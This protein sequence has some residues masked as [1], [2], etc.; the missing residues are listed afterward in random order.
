MP[1]LLEMICGFWPKKISGW[2]CPMGSVRTNLFEIYLGK[3]S[4]IHLVIVP[5]IGLILLP[6]ICRH[7][8]LV[9]LIFPT[10]LAFQHFPNPKEVE[11]CWT[12]SLPFRTD[13]QP[14]AWNFYSTVAA[15]FPT[16][17][18][19]AAL[20]GTCNC[21]RT[22]QYSGC[23]VLGRKYRITDQSR[24]SKVANNSLVEPHPPWEL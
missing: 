9:F 13:Y 15:Q 11:N 7:R 17:F 4:S 19:S 10:W 20:H 24:G 12:R 23:T 2:I 16:G 8:T 5:L 18:L 3:L 6:I 21:S 22:I 14:E 1:L